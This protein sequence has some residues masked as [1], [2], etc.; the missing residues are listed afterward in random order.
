MHCSRSKCYGMLHSLSVIEI[1]TLLFL[2]V[3]HYGVNS[4]FR[5]RM[6]LTGKIRALPLSDFFFF[7]CTVKEGAE[8]KTGIFHIVRK[9]RYIDSSSLSRNRGQINARIRHCTPESPFPFPRRR[10]S[11]DFLR[12]LSFPQRSPRGGNV[13]FSLL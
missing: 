4:L 11:S 2:T 5:I 13:P 9:T 7:V 1:S 10:Y 3:V 8:E 12:S 6:K